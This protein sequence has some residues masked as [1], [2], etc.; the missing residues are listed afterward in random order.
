MASRIYEANLKQWDHLSTVVPQ[1]EVSESEKPF[2]ELKPAAWL[3]VARF[4]KKFEEY[5]VVNSGKVVALDR[6]GRAVPAGLRK[7][8]EAAGGATVLTYVAADVAEK[9][10]DLT[11]GQAVTGAVSYTQTQVTNALRARGQITATEYARDFISRPIGYAP[12]S[13][14]CWGGSPSGDG[15]N[16]AG[17]RKHNHLLQH[18]V[19]VGCDKIIQVP[20][21][22]ATVA[23]ETMGTG[24]GIQ[25]TAI[26]FGTSGA[27]AWRDST[28]ISL[29]S[30]Y[31]SLVSAGDSVIAYVFDQYPVAKRTLSTPITDSAGNLASMTEVSSIA[32]VIAGGSSYYYIDY[33]VG[34]LFLYEAGGNAIPAGWVDGTTTITYRSYETSAAGSA[35]FASALG[36]LRPGDFVTYSDTSDYIKFVPDVGTASGGAGGDAYAADPDYSAGVD[37]AISAQLEAAM[38]DA[39]TDVV[40]QVIAILTFPRSG[41]E[42]VAT[43]FRQLGMLERMPGT[44]TEGLPDV[45]THAG[46]SNRVALINFF[47]R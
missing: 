44:A 5:A 42:K 36:D 23:A 4:D 28:S 43:Q 3:P 1:L 41:M 38:L 10:I 25:A 15:F 33:E 35:N 30:R 20:L 17:F 22:P 7:V 29:T 37:S 32:A 13:Y 26:V 9:V 39:Q 24:A 34:V 18:Q 45:L 11:T 27:A 16:P 2:A 19:A 40:G 47:A 8:F 31:S 46:G 14:W 12:Y 6:T 21:V